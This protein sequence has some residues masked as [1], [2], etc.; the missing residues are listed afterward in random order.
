MADTRHKEIVPTHLPETAATPVFSF[1]P[2]QT[3]QHTTNALSDS[4]QYGPIKRD[5][6]KTMILAAALV[7][8]ELLLYMKIGR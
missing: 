8:I 3:V 2:Q 5:L 4:V 7:I 1:R 6:A